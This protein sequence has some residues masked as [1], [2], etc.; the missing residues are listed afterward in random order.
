[1]V[2]KASAEP[3]KVRWTLPAA[4]TSVAEWLDSQHSVSESLRLLIREEIQRS[5]YADMAYKPVEQLPRR[6]RPP[7][8]AGQDDEDDR[9]AGRRPGPKAP[10]LPAPADWAE[11][12]EGDPGVEEQTPAPAEEPE[13]AEPTAPEQPTS[14]KGIP[15]GMSDFLTGS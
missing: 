10:K 6:G 2:Q 1:M 15:S 13:A 14:A 4:D 9:D 12:P 5:G 7:K 11:A 3:R 8:D